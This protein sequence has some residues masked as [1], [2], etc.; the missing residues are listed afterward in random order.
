[1]DARAHGL[2]RVR[3][4][5]KRR[6]GPD[7]SNFAPVAQERGGARADARYRRGRRDADAPGV[8]GTAN[9][10]HAFWA[11]PTDAGPGWMDDIAS[12]MDAEE[13]RALDD[14]A[15]SRPTPTDRVFHELRDIAP[16]AP[17]ED[18]PDGGDTDDPEDDTLPPAASTSATPAPDVSATGFDIDTVSDDLL[19]SWHLDLS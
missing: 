12:E 6:E 14:L 9:P 18:A 10:D 8:R 17:V 3:Y 7:Q 13:S 15:R 11:K 1:M 4:R 2:W 5:G 16:P 19:P